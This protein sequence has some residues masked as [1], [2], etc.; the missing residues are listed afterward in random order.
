MPVAMRSTRKGEKRKYKGHLEN[1]IAVI[2]EEMR[3]CGDKE[4][5]EWKELLLKTMRDSLLSI[6]CILN[7][8]IVVIQYV[9]LEE[10]DMKIREEMQGELIDWENIPKLVKADNVTKHSIRGLTDLCMNY[11]ISMYSLS[12]K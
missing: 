6:I 9:M 1:E 5:M 2:S 10:T 7:P 11:T 8:E 3:R 4:R 12:K